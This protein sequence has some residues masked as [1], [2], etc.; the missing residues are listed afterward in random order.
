[1]QRTFPSTMT[2]LSTHDT[3]RSDDV[4]ARLA[5]LTEV[6]GDF[7]T[8]A[9]QWS[10]LTAKYRPAEV[11]AGTEWFLYQTMVGA[12]P[13]SAERLKEYMQK[14]M[15]EAKER[16]SWVANNAEYEGAVNRFVDA[17]L[18]DREFVEGVERMVGMV[19]E[20]G[21]LNSLTQ[22]LVKY[23]APGVP[24]LYQ[25]GELWDLS[26]VD[27]DNRRPVDYALRRKLLEELQGMGAAEV[28]ERMEEGLPKLW[29][30]HRALQLRGEHPEWFDAGASYG[31]LAAEGEWSESV[32]AFA[33]GEN[34]VTVAGRHAIQRKGG[35][36]G[37]RVVLGE[38][39]WLN[40]LTQERVQGGAVELSELLQ[41]FPV[42][43]LTRAQ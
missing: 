5:V 31:A 18:G 17:A 3:K 40:R 38:G 28:M 41:V 22:T 37:T 32:I 42:A 8:A 9:R 4:R 43:L 33:R 27:P 20:A 24:D 1:M 25:G 16:T 13:I 12:W 2:T 39:E 7:G 29:V 26:L 35:W 6:A 14:A 23:A 11:D 34:V 15:R 36:G 21:R 10:A 30:I 19:L